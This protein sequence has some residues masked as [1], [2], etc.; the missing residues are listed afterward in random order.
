M[1]DSP[2]RVCIILGTRPE[3]IKL[4]PVI[5]AFQQDSAFA[6]E[7][8]LTGQHREMVD[9]VMTLFQLQAD[10]DLAIMQPQQTLTDITCR[11][12]QGLE[13]HFQTQRPDLVIVQ[14][15]TTTA[16]AAAL[17]AF[18]QKSPLAM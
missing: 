9:Q 6:T 13:A 3:A 11:S 12:L 14:G 4:A 15:D 1:S 16:F 7:V 8:I 2:R 18:Y 17:A 10:A 5:R